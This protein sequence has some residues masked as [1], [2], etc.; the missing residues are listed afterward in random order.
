MCYIKLNMKIGVY[1]FWFEYIEVVLLQATVHTPLQ[2]VILYL[3][4]ISD[5]HQLIIMA[6][7]IFKY[8]LSV[9]IV[10]GYLY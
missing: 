5:L 3:L 9:G 4:Y 7:Y 1:S 8:L 6:L 2:L 10:D